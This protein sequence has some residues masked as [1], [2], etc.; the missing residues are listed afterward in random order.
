LYVVPSF[1][2]PLLP[3]SPLYSNSVMCYVTATFFPEFHMICEHGKH[4]STGLYAYLS[5]CLCN[6]DTNSTSLCLIFDYK[7]KSINKIQSFIQVLHKSLTSVYSWP[8]NVHQY[9]RQKW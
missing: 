1:L 2:L 6:S 8:S 5:D 4:T 3:P 9:K 7:D